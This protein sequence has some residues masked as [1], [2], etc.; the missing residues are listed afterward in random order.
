MSLMTTK[1]VFVDAVSAAVRALWDTTVLSQD[2]ALYGPSLGFTQYEPDVPAEQV[3]TI[4]GPGKGVLTIE[5]QQYG[6][7]S[8]YR[9]YPVTVSLDKFTSEL[10]WTEEDLHW[11]K[12]M[13]SSKRA[14]NLKNE[15]EGAVNALYANLNEEAC[16]VYYLGHGTTNLTGGDG[17]QL[18]YKAHTLR[19]GGTQANNFGTGDTERAFSADNFVEAVNRMNRF[20]DH[21]ARQMLKTRNLRVITSVELEPTVQQALMSLYG[22]LNANLG[23]QKGSKGAFAGRGVNVDYIV[24]PDVPYAYRNYWEV[25]DL[26][27]AKYLSFLAAAWMPRMADEDEKSKGVYKNEAS[28]LFGYYFAGWQHAFGSKGDASSIS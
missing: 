23:L 7:N 14:T 26:D 5:G 20:Q 25:I 19:A 4:S 16:K 28:T 17:F 10:K 9:G 2:S 8:R 21:N 11:L 3:S 6:A 18:F 12:K 24:A 1:N 22:P 13:P 15:V 27:R